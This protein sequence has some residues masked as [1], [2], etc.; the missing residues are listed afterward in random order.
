MSAS[1]KIRSSMTVKPYIRNKENK[2]PNSIGGYI[3]KETSISD[4]TLIY[5]Y[6]FESNKRI[7]RVCIGKKSLHKS[8]V[9]RKNELKKLYGKGISLWFGN[10]C[11]TSSYKTKKGQGKAA[12]ENSGFIALYDGCFLFIEVH[13]NE[14]VH[15]FQSALKEGFNSDQTTVNGLIS[16]N[17][18]EERPIIFS[19]SGSQKGKK[20]KLSF[21]DEKVVLSLLDEGKKQN[22]VASRFGVSVKTIYNIKAR[23]S[24]L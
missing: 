20:R 15:Q 6:S 3:N 18:F 5:N 12:L 7:E 9:S 22:A 14:S 4:N 19:Y 1:I 10:I 17:T 24:N 21:N 16:E 11:E 2:K 23:H 8:F 13:I